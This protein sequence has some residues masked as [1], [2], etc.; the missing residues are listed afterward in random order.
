MPK[1]DWK[2]KTV[3]PQELEAALT[4]LEDEEFEVQGI[5]PLPAA[6]KVSFTVIGKKK[7]P[8]KR[9]EF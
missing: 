3:D 9:P 1:Y 6:D 5:H 8:N 4:A 7:R 2:V